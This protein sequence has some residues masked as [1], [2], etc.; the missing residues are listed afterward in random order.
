MPIIG[1]SK[2][3]ITGDITASGAIVAEEFKTD[4]ISGSILLNSG[5]TIFGDTRDDTHAFTGSLSLSGSTVSFLGGSKVGIGEASPDVSLEI[6]GAHTSNKGLL[7]IDSSDHAFIALDA[8]NNSSDSGI[9]F[10]E[11]GTS[12]FIIDHDGSG[13]VLRLHDGSTEFI[14]ISDSTG[15]FITV[16][17]ISGSVTSTGSFARGHFHSIGI[18]DTAPDYALD[19]TAGGDD[20]EMVAAFRGAQG[21]TLFI[22]NT[23]TGEVCFRVGS[24]DFITFN[25]GSDERLRID[26]DGKVGIGTTSP[27]Q[28]LHVHRGTAGTVDAGSSTGIVLEDDTSVFMGFLTPNNA[29]AGILFGDKEDIDIGKIV[30]E[31]ANNKMTFTAAA[32]STPVLSLTSNTAEFGIANYKVSGSSTSTGSFGA[33][34]VGGIGHVGH[35]RLQ[36][37]ANYHELKED[38]G[39]LVVMDDNRNVHF[40]VTNGGDILPGSDNSFDLGSASKRWANLFVGDLELS[41]EGSGGN[42]VD[43]TEGKW[44]IQEGE[45]NLYLLNRKNNKK[46]KF[47]LEEIE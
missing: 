24:G 45:E 25:E 37:G 23:A 7:H 28:T 18:N 27:D 31:H 8:H 12:Q 36:D 10:Q 41:N 15:D 26:G 3:Q 1:S 39:S 22:E 32:S 38:G 19:V 11:N 5:S 30:Y 34:E 14:T 20:N 46:Y 33:V 29:D 6:A 44:T 13:N 35:L 9:L 42:D 2:L 17:D 21:G 4:F 47:L 16:G 43:G 40:E